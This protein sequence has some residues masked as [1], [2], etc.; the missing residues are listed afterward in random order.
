MEE[1]SRIFIAGHRGMVGS[2][3]HRR[4]ADSH[5]NLVLRSRAEL[6]LSDKNAV[7]RLFKNERPEYVFLAAA[8]VGGIQANWSYQGE[9]IYSNLAIQ[10]NILEAARE[11][12]VRRLLFM[13]SSCVYPR[14]CPQPIR[15]EYLLTSPLET[16][17]RAYAVAKIAG[18]E[19]CGAYNRQYGTKFLAVMPTNLYGLNDNY[20][21]QSSHVLPA[22]IRKF[23][24]AKVGGKS[25]VNVW[26]TG[27]ARREF[28]NSEDLAD[29]CVFLMNLQD[30][31]FDAL[32]SADFPLINIGCGEDMTIREL[33]EL[34]KA[35]IEFEGAIEWDSSKPD[36]TP[37][38]LLDVSRMSAL[39]WR[40]HTPLREGIALAYADYNKKQAAA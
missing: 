18:I 23:H 39:G 25:T 35:V 5:P 8:K 13:G 28:L 22:L 37:R 1:S 36:G 6:D 19:M 30:E 9:F 21:L 4:L 17:N 15:E 20:D 26:G 29:A 40:A 3:L 12:G 10:V 38:K 14:E 34:V 33:T 32:L 31:R 11:Y 2:A 24:E 7:V 16:T 27:S